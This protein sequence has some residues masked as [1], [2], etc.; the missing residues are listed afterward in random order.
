MS[1][2]GKALH[3]MQPVWSCGLGR[4][5]LLRGSANGKASAATSPMRGTPSS[6]SAG[7][8]AILTCTK[9]QAP[10]QMPGG[11]VAMV[12]IF[13]AIIA[14]GQGSIYFV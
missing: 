5:R 9:V 1:H 4:C 12:G 2:M 8:Q 7:G 3:F 14:H 6:A 11:F 13:L 10:F